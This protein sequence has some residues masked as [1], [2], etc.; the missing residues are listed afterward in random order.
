[1]AENIY[2]LFKKY[3]YDKNYTLEESVENAI[4]K[5][6]V[7]CMFYSI[8]YHETSIYIDKYFNNFKIEKISNREFFKEMKNIVNENN[9]RMNQLSF[10]KNGKVDKSMLQNIK[11]CK[12]YELELIEMLYKNDDDYNKII[13]NKE[14]KITK[15]KTTAVEKKKLKNG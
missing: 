5:K 10:Y 14:K 11:Y 15:K 9:I 2:Y 6:F 8:D 13:N 7:L 3:L 12:L 1:M 4:M